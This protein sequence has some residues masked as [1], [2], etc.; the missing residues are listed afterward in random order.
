MEDKYQYFLT[1]MSGGQE[2]PLQFYSPG[3]NPDVDVALGFE[4]E[5][6]AAPGAV[7]PPPA[8]APAPGPPPRPILAH[9][10]GIS[11]PQLASPAVPS[12]GPPSGPSS[13]PPLPP[14][15]APVQ[16]HSTAPTPA[17]SSSSTFSHAPDL[18]HPFSHGET[19]VFSIVD[20]QNWRRRPSGTEQ[21]KHRRTRSGCFTCRSRRVKCDEGRPKC[22]RCRKGNRDCKYPDPDSKPPKG[23]RRP[24]AKGQ[25]EFKLPPIGTT[26]YYHLLPRKHPLATQKDSA[27]DKSPTKLETIP[28]QDEPET[29]PTCARSSIASSHNDHSS[30]ID[31][32]RNHASNPGS[33]PNSFAET[34][35]KL[36]MSVS[37]SDSTAASS[38]AETEGLVGRPPTFKNYAH[39]SPDMQDCLDWY[40]T[41]ITHYHYFI[42]SDASDFFA[43]TLPRLALLDETLLYG[44]V[45][46][47]AYLRALTNPNSSIKDFLAYF[48]RSITTMI[49]HLKARE[50]TSVVRL[51]SILQL[52]TLEEY[53]G[54]WISVMGHQMAARHHI[55]MLYN[56]KSF[57]D[58]TTGRVLLSWYA[59]FDCCVGIMGR[60]ETALPHEWFAN[61]VDILGEQSDANAT[62]ADF[63]IEE[64]ASHL[65]LCSHEIAQ[66]NY[67]ISNNRITPEKYHEE[68]V[69]ISALMTKYFTQLISRLEDPEHLID[70]SQVTHGASPYQ[71]VDLTDPTHRLYKEPLFGFNILRA[72][73]HSIFIMHNF[74]QAMMD[75]KGPVYLECLRHAY[76]ICAIFEG[77]YKYTSAPKGSILPIQSC[78]GL[79][80]LF[81]P[82]DQRHRAWLREMFAHVETIGYIQ[83]TSARKGISKFFN[84][85]SVAQWWYPDEQGFTKILRSVRSYTDAR[86]LHAQQWQEELRDVN[87]IFSALTIDSE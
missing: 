56:N 23:S 53:L 21:V 9:T 48:N 52:A 86:N 15:T 13:R 68:H 72:E 31:A 25:E 83:S 14:P 3:S 26:Q 33:S 61:H 77:T 45:A 49:G 37:P 79:G 8:P 41:N 75:K 66:L 5:A 54:D 16:A 71:V 70:F 59:R 51:V 30:P 50:E 29:L 58:T 40:Y 82:Q 20:G 34:E 62:S 2:V 64:G 42:L 69:R 76:A 39:L 60:F 7:A 6:T 81:F 85:E 22:E 55:M 57:M 73:F 36:S 19:T 1:S 17:S 12:L 24:R 67:N 63:L 43:V 78:L 65:R 74:Q 4:I 84:D 47:A 46:F 32:V 38:A 27:V 11:G 18:P 28:D 87:H 80:A 10:A 44:L 35:R